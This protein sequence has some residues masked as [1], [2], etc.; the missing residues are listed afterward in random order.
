[1]GGSNGSFDAGSLQV[2]QPYF[3]SGRSG[4]LGVIA[5]GA[6]VARLAQLGMIEPKFGNV[7]QPT[8]IKVSAAR[9]LYAP[10]TG[11]S[12]TGGATFE[13]LKGIGTPAVGGTGA[14]NHTP[15]RR[16]TTGYPAIS[17]AETVLR[18]AGTDALTA[19]GFTPDDATGPLGWVSVGLA[20]VSSASGGWVPFDMCPTTLEAGE[21][22]EVRASVASTGSGILIVAFDFL[23]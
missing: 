21:C 10:Q 22:L 16:K 14:A 3:I 9:M 11:G 17:A 18:V 2:A 6:P 19:T 8:P 23:R 12:P 5:A 15:Q 1:M 13:L 7:L 4:V 20:D